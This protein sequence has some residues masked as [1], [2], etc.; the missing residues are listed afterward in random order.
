M[1]AAWQH[2][3]GNFLL[4][5]VS[6]ILTSLFSLAVGMQYLLAQH[7]LPVWSFF[8]G[9]IAGSVIYLLRQYRIAPLAGDAAIVQLVWPSP[10]LC[11]WL[12]QCSLMAAL[13]RCFLPA[14]LL[15]VQ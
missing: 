14:A 4:V 9:L 3:N 11:L 13:Q 12:Q 7:P 8:V 15:S 6:G 5:L 2:I 1:A 10:G